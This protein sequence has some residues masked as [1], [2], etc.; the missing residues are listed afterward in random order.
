LSRQ[1]EIHRAD[2]TV[3]KV[4][5][6]E[7]PLSVGGAGSDV[8][9]AGISGDGP[10]A[11]LGIADARVFLQ[12]VEGRPG[13][14]CNGATV[15]SS[16]WLHSGD[17]LRIGA[18][19]VDV[20]AAPQGLRLKVASAV[21]DFVTEPPTL[22]PGDSDEAT[23]SSF[24]TGESL[25]PAEYRPRSAAVP[26]GP[27]RRVRPLA[28]VAWTALLLL[29]G[30]AWI[31]FSLRAVE[32][33]V[34]PE[35]QHMEVLGDWP[36]VELGGRYLL[37]P[38]HYTIVAERPGYR[39]L[40]LP[41]EIDSRTPRRLEFSLDK[42][43]GLLAIDVGKIVGA[44][45]LIDGVSHGTTPIEPIEL[46][47]GDYDLRVCAERFTEFRATVAIEGGGRTQT[48]VAEM[49][50]RWAAI[51][52]RSEPGGASLL[53]DGK[54]VGRTPFTGDLLEG[55]HR[56]EMS[57]PGYKPH[58]GEIEVEANRPRDLPP[59]EL[60]LSDGVLRLSSEPPGA[61][62]T[63][64]W[65]FRGRTPADLDLPPRRAVR[66]ELSL[67]GYDDQFREVELEPGEQAE[68]AVAL[69][70]RLG[71]ISITVEPADSALLVDGRSVGS[72]N[73]VLQLPA[74]PHELEFAREG[75]ETFR[76]SVTPR[77]GFPQRLDVTLV[78]PEQRERAAIP[79]A[80]LAPQ[81]HEMVLVE[82]GSFRMGASRREP[83][84]RANEAFRDVELTRAFYIS[85][86]EISNEAFRKFAPNHLSGRAGS[87]NL[88]N[89]SHPVV[90]VTWEDAARYCNWLSAQ[91]SPP[92]K[93]A[94]QA[95]S[96]SVGSR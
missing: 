55:R 18:T 87:V 65:E 47:A 7:F 28:A 95:H 43:P 40:E 96:A 57:L 29:A 62:I 30:A 37:H 11:W 61:S 27:R 33:R 71:E 68:I 10:V 77:P 90:R 82:G 70:A 73:T 94:T 12:C 59:V 49:P 46:P 35:P 20:E 78:T 31:L 83:G 14:E 21:H 38:G 50:G 58:R 41:I 80:I 81:G 15:V 26:R 8:E 23:V 85:K 36:A 66:L 17:E 53:I 1:V 45:V 92:E 32:L 88:E 24:G 93:R 13:V 44:E 51:V 5:E 56:Y 76:T 34:E 42:L 63:I 79:D 60:Q 64:D 91:E 2:G 69:T 25:T 89:D 84:R 54:R 39:P 16:Q 74:A 6:S 19:R 48:I 22:A 75:Y 67:M 3:R 4:R 9:V 52:F 86:H 72:A